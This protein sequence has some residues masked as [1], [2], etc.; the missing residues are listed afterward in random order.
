VAEWDSAAWGAEPGSI[1]GGGMTALSLYGSNVAASTLA[2]AFKASKAL[3]GIESSFST[4][5]GFTTT[6]WDFF[7]PGESAT[8]AAAVSEPSPDSKGFILDDGTLFN[9]ILSLGT[10]T[11]KV[12]ANHNTLGR[13]I[14]ADMHCRLYRYDGTFNH[15]IAE[16]NQTGNS[17]TNS[18]TTF[19]FSGSVSATTFGASD[20]LY[21][22]FPVNITTSPSSSVTLQYYFSTSG[23]AGISGDQ[24]VDTAGFTPAGAVHFRI[25][26]GYGGC[27]S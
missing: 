9:Q 22:D 6:G 15:L 12:T 13:T 23:T 4:T 7:S 11:I 21:F 16:L 14:T 3:T 10:F 1:G 20:H 26:D 2:T 25:Q 19:S 27:F 8:W 24:E 18:K 5:V 17:I